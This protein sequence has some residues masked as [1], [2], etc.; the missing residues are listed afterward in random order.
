MGRLFTVMWRK[1]M[2]SVSYRTSSRIHRF[3]M[4]INPKDLYLYMYI[5]T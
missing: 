3:F 1:A 4:L 2:I 5:A